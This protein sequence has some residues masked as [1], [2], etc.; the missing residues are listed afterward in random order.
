MESDGVGLVQILHKRWCMVGSKHQTGSQRADHQGVLTGVQRRIGDHLE[1]GVRCVAVGIV[2]TGLDVPVIVEHGSA[3]DAETR[4]GDR[5]RP[6]D[7]EGEVGIA[8]QH[9]G[10]RIGMEIV[11]RRG[12]TNDYPAATI[13]QDLVPL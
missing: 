10:Q 2:H 3:G 7:G 12:Q 1:A 11:V 9:I 5:H 6:A 4:I 13:E 8:G